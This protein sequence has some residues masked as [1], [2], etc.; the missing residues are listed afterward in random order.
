[1]PFTPEEHVRCNCTMFEGLRRWLHEISQDAFS[2]SLKKHA[3]KTSRFLSATTC[4]NEGALCISSLRS[5]PSAAIAGPARV[6]AVATWKAVERQLQELPF[7]WFEAP[8]TGTAENHS[9]NTAQVDTSSADDCSAVVLLSS[10]PQSLED[11][12][13][14]LGLEG[15]HAAPQSAV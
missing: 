8:T 6:A 10:A 7:A 13:L 4:Q 14:F 9:F 1:M 12:R 3:H 15:K 5:H 11:F 2:L